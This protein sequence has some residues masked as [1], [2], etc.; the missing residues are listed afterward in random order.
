LAQI[1][2]CAGTQFD[3]QYAQAFL[4]L[5]PAI[6]EHRNQKEAMSQ[7]LSPRPMLMMGR[8]AAAESRKP[9][10]PRFEEDSVLAAPAAPEVLAEAV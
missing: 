6:H 1:K 10:S 4:Q 7:T 8:A 3:P 2:S 9:R 5:R